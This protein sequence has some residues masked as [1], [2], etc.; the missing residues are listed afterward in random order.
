MKVLYLSFS[1]KWKP[2]PN[3]LIGGN[4]FHWAIENQLLFSAFPWWSATPPNVRRDLVQK[5]ST[6]PFLFCKNGVTQTCSICLIKFL[7]FFLSKLSKWCFFI[8]EGER[9]RGSHGNSH[10]I[11]INNIPIERLCIKTQFMQIPL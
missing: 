9:E 5:V 10:K 6:F 2:F 4:D 11:T 8:A 7:W 3:P 1:E